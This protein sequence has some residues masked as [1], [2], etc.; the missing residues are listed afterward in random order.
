MMEFDINVSGNGGIDKFYV[1]TDW[2]RENYI[3]EKEYVFGLHDNVIMT[4][5]F[6][7]EIDAM[8][9]KLRWVEECL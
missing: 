2:L 3:A 8:A 7:D 9:F 6:F 5:F 4:V 1:V